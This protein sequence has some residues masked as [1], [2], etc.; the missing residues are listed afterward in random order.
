MKPDIVEFVLSDEF[1]GLSLSQAQ[2]TV[3]RVAYGLPLSSEQLDLYRRCT[4]RQGRP[5]EAGFGEVTVIAGARS[6]KDSRIAAPVVCYE[7]LCGGH[8]KLLARGERA[9]IPLVAQD[10]RATRVAFGYVRDYLTGSPLLSSMVAEVRNLE[11]ALINGV[12]IL[13]FPSTRRS[14][15]GWSIPAAVMDELAFFRLEGQADSDAEIQASIR[16]GMLSFPRPRLMKVSTPYMKSGVLYEDF[17]A[18]YGQNDPD[19]LVWKAPSALMNTSLKQARLERERRLD[20]HRFAREYE[21]EFAEDIDAFLPSVWVD[22]AVVAGRHELAPQAGVRYCGAVDVS[23]AGADA[24]TLAVAHI[25]GTSDERLIVQDVMRGWGSNSR[26]RINLESVVSDCAAILTRYR[27]SEVVGDRYAAGWVRE[28][29]QRQGIKYIDAKM[30]KADAYLE[31]EPLF[32]QGIIELLDEPTLV[33]EL[34]L[35]ESRPRAGGKTLVDHPRGG[36]DDH[37]NSLCL[38]A[39]TAFGSAAREPARLWSISR[40]GL[41]VPIYLTNDF[42]RF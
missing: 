8:E 12:T 1:L 6:G 33:R 40:P 10:L 11:I 4:G 31:C 16:R 9:I 22:D 23:G 38:A 5:P 37:A 29:Y 19:R 25:E 7:A 20:P 34:K 17:R 30:T 24:F 39:A 26:R 42:R 18:A 14:L 32:A 2:E 28:A 3:L 27:I 35:L 41:E 15:R 13:C 36:H 21:A